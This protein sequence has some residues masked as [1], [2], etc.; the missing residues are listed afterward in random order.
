MEYFYVNN[1]IKKNLI[2]V[3]F[4]NIVIYKSVVLFGLEKKIFCICFF[5]I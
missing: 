5:V 1:I 3:I 4:F 2:N